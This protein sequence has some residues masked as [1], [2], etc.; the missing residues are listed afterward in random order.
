VSAL[1]LEP[2]AGMSR[3][4]YLTAAG[5]GGILPV[6]MPAASSAEYRI[7]TLEEAEERFGL[8][9]TLDVP[10][11]REVAGEQEVRLYEGGLRLD[12]DLVMDDWAGDELCPC[13]VIVAGDLTVGGSAGF[14]CGEGIGYFYLVTGNLRAR[15]VLMSGFPHVVVGG[16]LTATGGIQG[17]KGDDGGF[18]TVLGRTSAQVVVSMYYFTMTFSQRPAAVVISDPGYVNC[19][20]D[21]VVTGLD[22]I[23]QPGLHDDGTAS[24]DA[25]EKALMAGRPVLRPGVRPAWQ[26]TGPDTSR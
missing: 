17:Q 14:S 1:S 2:D 8:S 23:L 6:M 11:Y 26:A 22:A 4:E 18:L 12:G 5:C 13:S 24:P 7:I 20:V 9:A 10:Y 19:P 3:P 15:N 16:N 25:I 21:Y